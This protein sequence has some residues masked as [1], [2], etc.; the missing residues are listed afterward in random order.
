MIGDSTIR[1][2]HDFFSAHAQAGIESIRELRLSETGGCVALVSMKS[3]E[4]AS[5][6]AG[7]LGLSLFGFN[8]L[9]V[10]QSWIN[11]NLLD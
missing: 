8:T 9:I 11:N 6:V 5:Q 1:R 2:L 7:D 4:D 3:R 10:N